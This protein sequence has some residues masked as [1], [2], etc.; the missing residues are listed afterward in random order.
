M[1]NKKKEIAKKF[2]KEITELEQIKKLE[3]MVKNNQMD[4]KIGEK[5]YKV[6][7]PNNEE[8]SEIETF[9]IRKYKEL[10]E[11]DSMLFKEQWVELY[12]KKGIDII[13][14]EVNIITLQDDIEKLMVRLATISNKKDVEQLT[15]QIED[16]KVKQSEIHIDKTDKLN[17]SIE[18][19]LLHLV[20]T[21]YTYIV[22]EIKKGDKWSKAFDSYKSFM[23]S[24]DSELMKQAFYCANFIIYSINGIN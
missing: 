5:H 9:R 1:D 16:L 19:Q 12:K 17:C 18:D 11:D 22:L 8:Q 3:E 24:N 2:A 20:N 10:V 15:K 13:K 21:Y 6:R 23:S 4:F 14:M 7:K